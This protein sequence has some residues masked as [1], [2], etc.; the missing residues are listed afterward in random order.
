M[1]RNL[2]TREEICPVLGHFMLP[3]LQSHLP[4]GLTGRA[5]PQICAGLGAD[6]TSPG[7]QRETQESAGGEM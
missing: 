7:S 5:G 2:G 4:T 1:K 3:V 6:A